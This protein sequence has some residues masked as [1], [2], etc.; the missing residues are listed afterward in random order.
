M[1]MKPSR[2]TTGRLREHVEQFPDLKDATS[3]FKKCSDEVL[4][5]GDRM[6][7]GVLLQPE[8]PAEVISARR[9][10]ENRRDTESNYRVAD[11][12]FVGM[13]FR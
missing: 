9:K 5:H 10:S 13:P 4:W 2:G 11:D 12:S 7:F 8:L 6:S 1:R 3:S